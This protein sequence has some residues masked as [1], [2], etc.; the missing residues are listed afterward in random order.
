MQKNWDLVSELDT[1]LLLVLFELGI[2]VDDL[3]FKQNKE[4][5][6]FQVFELIKEI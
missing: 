1:E 2:I 4:E 6:K 3:K 5:K